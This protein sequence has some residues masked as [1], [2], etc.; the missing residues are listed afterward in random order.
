[1]PALPPLADDGMRNDIIVFVDK[2]GQ[3]VKGGWWVL[4]VALM[5]LLSSCGSSPAASPIEVTISL[6]Q[7][8]ISP[9][10]AVQGEVV[11]TNTT[12]QDIATVGCPGEWLQ[13]GLVNKQVNFHA[14]STL[15][16]CPHPLRLSPGPNR[17]SISVSTSYQGCS[18]QGSSANMP[19]CA[20]AKDDVVPPLPAG[21]YTTK[22]YAVVRG[23]PRSGVSS[24]HPVRVTL[25]AK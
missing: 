13:V 25:L 20:G 10:P 24:A 21:R 9:G 5:G 15:V 22:V 3:M 18:Q 7:T 16:L 4:G 2:T 23:G 1:M 12:S 14:T 19:H 17:F 11:V 6:S 8:R